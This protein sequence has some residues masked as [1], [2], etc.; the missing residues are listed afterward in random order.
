MDG[1]W[2][3]SLKPFSQSL[4]AVGPMLNVVG[5]FSVI[6]G[7]VG[8]Y[9]IYAVILA[10][11]ITILNIY[12]PFRASKQITTNGG[13]YTL[14]GIYLG[15]KA[16]IFT[17]IV[18]LIYGILAFPSITL[19][20]FTLLNFVLNSLTSLYI[21]IFIMIITVLIIIRG[22]D[23]T[24]NYL[25]Y[26]TFL[27]ITFILILDSLMCL[28]GNAT[29]PSITIAPINAWGFWVALLF[30]LL[31][32]AGLGSSLFIS[33]NTNSG[34]RNVPKGILNAYALSGILMVFSA[35]S[36]VKFLGNN[37]SSYASNPYVILNIIGMNFGSM[38]FY[39]VI[40]FSLLSSVNLSLA[41]LNAWRNA[42]DK[43]GKD[44]ILIRFGSRDAILLALLMTLLILFISFRFNEGFIGFVMV[45]GLVSLFYLTVHIISNVSYFKQV[46]IEMN[47]YGISIIVAST[48][49]LFATVVIT[50]YGDISNMIM[51]SYLYLSLLSLGFIGVVIY[52]IKGNAESVEIQYY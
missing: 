50:I 14:A 16:G 21:T 28:R 47:K 32:F 15:K 13:Y 33:E 31:M 49:L 48:I 11:I 25:K 30:S 26:L 12:V 17:S 8:G 35:Y 51:E 4:A 45:T 41:Y 39:L 9:L 20:Q 3:E 34:K 18:Y 24:I 44:K 10:F 22:F 46:L 2:S 52:S 40:L 6:A 7:L 42:I 36:I 43:M 38:V 19:F 27:E 5:L 29:V 23:L 37:I 1:S